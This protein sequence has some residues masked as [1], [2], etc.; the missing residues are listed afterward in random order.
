VNTW[1]GRGVEDRGILDVAIAEEQCFQLMVIKLVA[2]CQFLQSI[3]LDASSV[4]VEVLVSNLTWFGQR[5]SSLAKGRVMVAHNDVQTMVPI[6]LGRDCRSLD[7]SSWEDI[8]TTEGRGC[9]HG[10]EGWTWTG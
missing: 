9:Q 7:R 2:H 5:W 6:G 4:G 1:Q 8:R 3:L 10:R